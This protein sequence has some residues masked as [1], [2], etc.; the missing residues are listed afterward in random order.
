[1]IGNRGL[2]LFASQDRIVRV[3]DDASSPDGA[4]S[5]Q[6]VDLVEVRVLTAADWSTALVFRPGFLFLAPIVDLEVTL[7]L[8]PVCVVDAALNPAHLFFHPADISLQQFHALIEVD[9]T[10][11]LEMGPLLEVLLFGG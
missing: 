6:A 4:A 2:I 1:M 7:T 11:L 10:L 3:V 9:E 8:F 5:D